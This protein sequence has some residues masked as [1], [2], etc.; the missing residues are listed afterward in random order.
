MI[1]EARLSTKPGTRAAGATVAVEEGGGGAAE[2]VAGEGGPVSV[3]IQVNM[4]LG[5]ISSERRGPMTI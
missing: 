3:Y 1:S 2:V 4:L 5:L